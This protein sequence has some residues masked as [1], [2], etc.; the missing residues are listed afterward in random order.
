MNSLYLPLSQDI[1]MLFALVGAKIILLM[2]YT[3][4]ILYKQKHNF[5]S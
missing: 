5:K 3:D 1:L 4:H 2:S